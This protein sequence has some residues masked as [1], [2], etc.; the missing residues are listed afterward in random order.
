VGVVADARDA[1][2]G[3]DA[4]AMLYVPHAQNSAAGMA[5]APV[6][7]LVR[8]T[9][10]PMVAA[11]L[12]RRALL[13][14]DPELPMEAPVRVTEALAGS[15][16]PQRFQALLLA[17]FAMAGLLLAA[18]G[19]YGVTVHAVARQTREI[20]V[21]LALGA[22]AADVLR[23]VAGPALGAV[24]VGLLVGAASARA[25]AS[26][27]ARV[28]AGSRGWDPGLLALAAA[29]LAAVATAA[30]LVP[31]W[32]GVRLDPAEALRED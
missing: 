8:A 23:A 31:A 1:G 9:G 7:F 2:L 25:G 29:V 14:A 4:S 30:T 18:A 24:A 21:R 32:R 5:F 13:A 15:L 17:G 28:I 26:L 19:L 3:F 11:P 10:D 20:G 22:R 6:T 12:L 16:G 27:M